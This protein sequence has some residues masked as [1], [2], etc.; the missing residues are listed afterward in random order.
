MLSQF[1]NAEGVDVSVEALDFCRAARFATGEA[2][3]RPK[4]CPNAGNSLDLVTALDVVEH[5]HDD[6]AGLK[7]MRRVLRPAGTAVCLCRVHGFCGACRTIS[8]TI[9]AATQWPV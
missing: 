8:A 6:V 4:R 9:V 3:R 1:G 7:E 5:L 2:G